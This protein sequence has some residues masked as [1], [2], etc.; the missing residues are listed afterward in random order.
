MGTV[1][2]VLAKAEAAG[3]S[4]VEI[5]AAARVKQRLLNSAAQRKLGRNDLVFML[6]KCSHMRK[7]GQGPE[8][9]ET[10]TDKD[11]RDFLG[12][13]EK[14]CDGMKVPNEPFEKTPPEVFRGLIDEALSV[15]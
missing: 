1:E 6:E 7:D 15:K 13:A 14:F 12:K 8:V 3:L 5:E 9:N 2:N 4:A 10:L 11:I